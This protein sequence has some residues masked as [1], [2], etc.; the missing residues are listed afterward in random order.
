MKHCGLFINFADLQLYAHESYKL[1]KEQECQREGDKETE[2]WWKEN[3]RQG[4]SVKRNIT[5][6]F[7]LT[8]HL[9]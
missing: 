3:W 5:G 6:L 1:E 2:C 4:V 8:Q 7:E 9:R